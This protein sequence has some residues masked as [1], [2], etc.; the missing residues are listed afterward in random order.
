M[1]L[2]ELIEAAQHDVDTDADY[3]GDPEGAGYGMGQDT[4]EAEASGYLLGYLE[5]LQRAREALKAQV[6]A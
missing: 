5:G 4:E 3:W 1:T 2:D 6:P